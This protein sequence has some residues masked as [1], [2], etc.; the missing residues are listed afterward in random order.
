MIKKIIVIGV[1]LGIVIGFFF[2][3]NY[4]SE[5]IIDVPTQVFNEE[6]R[7]DVEALEDA[8]PLTTYVSGM[9]V[10]WAMDFL[11]D[12]RIVFTERV[13]NVHIVERDGTVRQIATLP[14]HASGEGG[15]HGIA[16][17]PQFASNQ[18]VYL[19]YTYRGNGDGIVNR[20]SRFT[21]DGSMLVDEEMII[22]AIPGA[23]TH[24]GG[25]IKFG[26]DE[27][28]YVTTGDAQVTS[29]S[30]DVNSLAG[31]ILRI[32]RD[33]DVVEGNPFNSPVYS[34]GHR[35]PQGITWDSEGN[36][37]ST[38][39]GP[40][41]RDELNRIEAGENYGW[42]VIVGNDTQQGMRSPIIH[43]GQTTW[44]P[45]GAQY[46]NGSVFFVGLRG[47][48]LYEYNLETQVLTEHLKNKLGRIRDII[49]G[50]DG[51]LY[52][53]TSNRDGRGVPVEADDRILRINPAKIGEL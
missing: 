32:K 4:I 18:F 26:P 30:Q 39:H 24:N 19:Y 53:S 9:R 5:R 49:L 48:A 33:G 15:L 42:P 8:A 21:W 25:R 44:A 13:G 20:V 51:F 12:G 2:Y 23:F 52:I 14:V 38:E 16:V 3:N 35:N 37:W 46:L 40:S 50:P 43:S 1:V 28:L 36:M 17:D 6:E 47:S 7:E 45:A 29:L 34:Y 11:S 31:K 10:I 27:Y 41:M 22:D